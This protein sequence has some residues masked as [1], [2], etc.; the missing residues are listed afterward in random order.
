MASQPFVAP[1]GNNA[2]TYSSQP[3]GIRVAQPPQQ[4]TFNPQGN[5]QYTFNPPATPYNQ[6]SQTGHTMQRAAQPTAPGGTA[7]SGNIPVPPQYPRLPPSHGIPGR[8]A[9]PRPGAQQTWRVDGPR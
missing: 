6:Q 7:A 9:D 3:Q 4:P 1:Q 8:R 5:Q 2:A